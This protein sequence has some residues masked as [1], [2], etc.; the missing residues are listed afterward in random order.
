MKPIAASDDLAIN[1]APINTDPINTDPINTAPIKVA[2]GLIRNEDGAWLCCQRSDDEDHAGLWEF[3]GGK[4]EAGENLQHALVRE[5][6]EEL[7]WSDLDGLGITPFHDFT[8]QHPGKYVHL[9]CG[10]LVLDH[11]PA[12]KLSVHQAAAWVQ[13]DDMGS[14]EW[15]ASNLPIIEDLRANYR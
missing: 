4:F 11:S 2:V 10:L 9:H 1:T 3:P 5:L 14:M 8:W 6:S 12:I 13:L 15:L 7:G